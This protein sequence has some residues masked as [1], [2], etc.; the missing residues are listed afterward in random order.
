VLTT[1]RAGI[2]LRHTLTDADGRPLHRGYAGHLG[3][4]V[5]PGEAIELT[6]GLPPL[7]PGSYPFHADLIRG[8][9]IEL[10]DT[11]FVQYGSE[12]AAATLTVS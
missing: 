1:G 3:R 12:P 2:R 7:P 6:C 8:E 5:P 10:L 4:T 9:P 11:A